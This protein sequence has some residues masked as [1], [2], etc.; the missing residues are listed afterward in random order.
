MKTLHL[1]AFLL[2]LIW[3]GLLL[4]PGPAAAQSL[5]P[6]AADTA[7]LWRTLQQAQYLV[8]T[9]T[10]E[11]GRR[12][13]PALAASRRNHFAEGTAAAYL[14]LGKLLDNRGEPAAALR[15]YQRA[16]QELAAPLR[17]Q[18][19]GRLR[20][21][22]S[23]TLNARSVAQ[24]ALGDLPGSIA[25]CQQAIELAL[26]ARNYDGLVLMYSN[27]ASCFAELGE[28]ARQ[29]DYLARSLALRRQALRRPEQLIFPYVSLAVRLIELGRRPEAWRYLQQAR[30]LLAQPHAASYVANYERA[31]GIYFFEEGRFAQARQ[32]FERARHLLEQAGK[33]G[34]VAELYLALARTSQA[35]GDGPGAGG[36]LRH[37]L[38]LARRTHSRLLEAELLEELARLEESQGPHHAPAALAYFQQ[39][40]TLRDTLGGEETKRAVLKLEAQ[41]RTRE[42]Q[43]QIRALHAQ[44][45]VQQL[46]LQHRTWLSYAA[47]ALAGVLVGLL[48]LAYFVLRT[49]QKLAA[50]T[51][52]RTQRE[53]EQ[54]RRQA[55]IEAMLHAQDAERSRIAHDLHDSLGGMLS[56]V[57]Y[58]LGTLRSTLALPQADEQ[59]FAH[60]LLHLDA[61]IGELRRVAHDMMP[62][63]LTQ[64]GLVPA[65][66]DLCDAF[67]HQE[68]LQVRF[69]TYGLA[70]R[71]PERTEVVVYRLV[72]EL[73]HNAL[74]HAEARQILVQ[75]MR[76]GAQVQVVAED[77]GV[78]FSLATA[79]PGMGL[80]NIQA[81]VDYL[82]GTLEWQSQPG[83]GTTAT[84][85]FPLPHA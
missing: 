4:A 64:F 11:A 21:G 8:Q 17:R 42:Q 32:H 57:K 9:D 41:Y 46:A 69:Q 18:P 38:A 6:A 80:R 72:Q 55:A 76:D 3:A 27:Q 1:P 14:L 7:A 10:A 61:A 59:V 52:L 5:P 13:R 23:M 45:Q 79:R 36:Q 77:N 16:E 53:L 54:A 68:Q 74:K 65:L 62:G 81:R 83:Q 85:D 31:C 73:L 33:L 39:L 47:L 78:G 34:R 25:S 48:G 20:S 58:Y 51:Q 19:T 66:Q 29:L 35:L 56:A 49:R 24:H 2:H 50:H 75:L 63:A 82:H 70:E 28:T 71:L 30:P 40:Q 44:H 26:A 43:Q 37:A 67:S 84:I 12:I 22:L 60:A 15:L